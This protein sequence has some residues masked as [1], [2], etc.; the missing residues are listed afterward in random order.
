MIESVIADRSAVFARRYRVAL[1]YLSYFVCRAAQIN[2][3]AALSFMPASLS[4]SLSLPHLAHCRRSAYHPRRSGPPHLQPTRY[5]VVRSPTAAADSGSPSR[6]AR[7]VPMDDKCS[8]HASAM[9][10][11][12]AEIRTSAASE[13]ALALKS[14][15]CA[16]HATAGL[17]NT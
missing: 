4:L 3:Y 13:R 16:K 12:T 7:L 6:P 9:R 17:Q 11:E 1:L 8:S 2:R 10:L 14:D 5:V 15:G